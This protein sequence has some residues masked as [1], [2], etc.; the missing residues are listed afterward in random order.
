MWFETFQQ[1]PFALFALQFLTRVLFFVVKVGLEVVRARELKIAVA[2]VLALEIEEGVT[3]EQVP[4]YDRSLDF[5]T[6]G[7]AQ[8]DSFHK[9]HV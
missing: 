2:L 5:R 4:V 3:L 6:K 7:S 8:E 1:F 9:H